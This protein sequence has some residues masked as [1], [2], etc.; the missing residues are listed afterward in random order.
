VSLS[1]FHLAVGVHDLA[2]ARRFYADDLGCRLGREDAR[3]ID[4]DL[5]GHQ[6]TAHLVDAAEAP[7]HAP[8][9]G[10]AVP[11][12]HFGVVLPW[13]AW[14]ALAERLRARGVAFL[15]GPRVRFPGE[16]GEQGT[17]FVRDPSGNALE[18]KSFRDPG[19]LFST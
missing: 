1:P 8:V 13:P 2:A 17:F 10:D 9:D 18:F 14:E 7:A 5:F 6:V 12:P 15:I 4:F 11:V 3:W 16:V 19:R